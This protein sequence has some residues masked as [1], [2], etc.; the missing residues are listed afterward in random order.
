MAAH[1]SPERAAQV[2]EEVCEKYHIGCSGAKVHQSGADT[3]DN[4]TLQ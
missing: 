2:R 3:D 1:E 4:G